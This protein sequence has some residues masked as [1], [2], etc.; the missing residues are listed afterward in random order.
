VRRLGTLFVLRL[1]LVSNTIVVIVVGGISLAFVE[2]PAGVIGAALC[3]LFA[4][5]LLALLPL[6]D[7]YRE[8]RPVRRRRP[9]GGARSR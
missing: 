3:W 9:R 4:G 5:C 6:T 1:L 7:P 8:D 2:R